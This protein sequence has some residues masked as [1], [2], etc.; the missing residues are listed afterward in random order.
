MQSGSVK[1]GSRAVQY[2]TWRER[3][4]LA[5]TGH[6]CRIGCRRARWRRPVKRCLTISTNM[7]W[8]D[9]A[10]VRTSCIAASSRSRTNADVPFFLQ[11]NAP[12]PG[13]LAGLANLPAR[14]LASA[15]CISQQ[16]GIQI[17]TVSAAV[18]APY[19]AG[20]SAYKTHFRCHV[21][22]FLRSIFSSATR[23]S[24][25]TPRHPL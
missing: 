11:I 15:A 9:P 2:W 13:S 19:S 17:D 1:Y 20:S 7:E 5:A 25:I 24:R 4:M 12:R 14:P 18:G 6:R 22:S 16:A 10:D 3:F 8:L 21:F 23:S